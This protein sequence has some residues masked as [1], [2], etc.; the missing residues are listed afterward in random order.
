MSFNIICFGDSITEGD[1]FPP[2]CR[3]TTLLQEQLDNIQ[4]GLCQVHNRGIGS[5][6]TAQGLDRFAQDV[7]PL[8]PGLVLVQFGFNDANVPSWSDVP[9]VS[10]AEFER[11]LIEFHRV[12]VRKHGTCVFVVNH[13]I[14]AVTGKQG[15]GKTFNENYMPYSDAVRKLALELETP[16]VD[17]P[18]LMR[19]R[20]INLDD[21]LS[22]DLIHLSLEAN[23][24]Y[25]DMIFEILRSDAIH[26]GG[27]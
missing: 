18:L 8:L 4:P 2:E 19:Q 10:L 26:A 9:R 27:H 6:T 22:L 23:E 1:E 20:G 12:I 13:S 15:N 16:C 21:F 17:L 5:D 11:N 3:W 25:A 24:L 7:L 14:G